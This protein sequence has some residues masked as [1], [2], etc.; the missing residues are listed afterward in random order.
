MT[1]IQLKHREQ[2]PPTLQP[3]PPHVFCWYMRHTIPPPHH[4]LLP[5]LLQARALRKEQ[6]KRPPSSRYVHQVS[7]AFTYVTR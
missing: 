1:I 4:P 2:R 6:V 7:D 3:N 5:M